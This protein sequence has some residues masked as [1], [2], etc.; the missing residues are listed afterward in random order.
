L[1]SEGVQPG[2]FA[3]GPEEK[4]ARAGSLAGFVVV[5][6]CS[7]LTDGLAFGGEG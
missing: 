5:M 7:I 6:V 4:R 1:R 2:I 3:Q